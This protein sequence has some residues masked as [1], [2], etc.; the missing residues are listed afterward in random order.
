MNS[1]VEHLKADANLAAV[2]VNYGLHNPAPDEDTIEVRYGGSPGY[3]IHDNTNGDARLWAD[4]MKKLSDADAETAHQTGVAYQQLYDLTNLA[5]ASIHEWFRNEDVAGIAAF[6]TTVEELRSDG[7]ALRDY[8]IAG[9][10]IV[11]NI[12]WRN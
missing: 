11:L 8:G 7:D 6:N 1:L 10:R 5:L 12:N 9:S 4:V 2:Q 3:D